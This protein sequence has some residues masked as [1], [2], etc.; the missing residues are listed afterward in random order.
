V[1]DAV[2]SYLDYLDN[3]RR[4]GRDARYRAE[5]Q[6]YPTL[7]DVEV[8]SLTPEALRRWQAD[9]VKGAS[10]IRTKKGDKQKFKSVPDTEEARRRRRATVNRV[11]GL[12]KAAL[13]RAWRDGKVKS[14]DA[15]RRVEPY[16]Q[17]V[18]ARVRY[19]TVA[20]ARRLINACEPGFRELVQAALAT[21][22]RYGELVALRV[23]D[24]DPDAGTLT[25][26]MA[27]NGRGRHIVLADEGV[28]LFRPLAAGK[29]GNT[30]LLPKPDGTQWKKT[31]QTYH[32]VQACKGA[33]IDPPIGF[34]GLRHTWASLAVM[35]GM[36]LMVVAR[37]LGHA[38]TRM[39]ERHYGHMAPDYINE[40]IRAGSPKFGIEPDRNV[41]AIG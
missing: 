5:A 21:G 4:S 32:M 11:L 25:V 28:K 15:W 8:A 2:E 9:L 14:D 17:A 35:G 27:K 22:A 40:A 20:E 29:L 13:N 31:Q 12:L 37:Q 34:H 19:L 3:N 41:A 38:D 7:G 39:V 30:V 10:R 6:I 24:F 16:K 26:R 1:R 23:S 36:P 33:K 18:A